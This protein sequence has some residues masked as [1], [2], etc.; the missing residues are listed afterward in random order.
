MRPFGVFVRP[1]GH[2]QDAMVHA[3]QVNEQCVLSRDDEDADKVKALEFFAPH[4]SQVRSGLARSC[5]YQGCKAVACR[6]IVQLPGAMRRSTVQSKTKLDLEVV[7]YG[8][9][10]VFIKVLEVTDDGG[11]RI[12]V[13]AS[14]RVVRICR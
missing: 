8:R 10:Q 14:M 5:L 3:S 13:G 7:P 4:R 11:G 2:P 6:Y 12:K 9:A 1:D